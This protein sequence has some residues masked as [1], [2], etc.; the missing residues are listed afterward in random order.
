MDNVTDINKIR[1]RVAIDALFD[2]A[3]V[4]GVQAN[5]LSMIH[6]FAN[7]H[8]TSD[9]SVLALPAHLDAMQR[10]AAPL[11]VISWQHGQLPMHPPSLLNFKQSIAASFERLQGWFLKGSTAS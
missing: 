3:A 2:P 11:P 8:E 9:V 6:A 5:A 1:P 7:R 10:A 4:G